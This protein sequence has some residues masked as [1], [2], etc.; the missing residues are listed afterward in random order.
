MTAAPTTSVA[1]RQTSRL[2]AVEHRASTF[3]FWVLLA[4]GLALRIVLLF[5]NSFRVDSDNAV[6]YLI[7]KHFSEGDVAWFFW[8]QTYGGTLLE[9]VAG[10]AMVVFGTHVEVLSIVGALFFVVATLLVRQIATE[11]FGRRLVGNVAGVLFWFPGYWMQRVGT[12]E[13]GFYG[14]SLMLGLLT[15]WLVLRGDRRKS[16]LQWALIGLAAGLAL[17]QSPMGIAIAAP[18][19]LVAVIRQFSPTRYLVGIAAAVLGALPWIIV[20]LTTATAVKPQRDTPIALVNFVAFFSRMLPGVL[21]FTHT[22]SAPGPGSTSSAIV[23]YPVAIIAVALIV[24]LLVLAITKRSWWLGTL[25]ASTVTVVVVVVLGTGL[26]LEVDSVRYAIFV[27][28]AITIGIAYVVTL[29]PLAGLGAM[30]VA[31]AFTVAQVLIIF[32]DLRV[33]RAESFIVGN[34]SV[35]GDYLEANDITGAYA[36]YW[37]S[38]SVTAET[39]ERAEVAALSGPR[40]YAPYEDTAQAAPRATVIVLRDNDNDRML[41][42]DASLPPSVRTEVGDYAVYSFA[43]PF[44][45]YSYAWAL[46]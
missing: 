41:Q 25:V 31:V 29:V 27:L 5:T 15:I 12:S 46:Y 11:A 6:V 24:M 10:A 36:D 35:L 30:A 13:P 43:Q 9:M 7:A 39:G 23:R 26:I 33:S 45:A 21:S 8:G 42:T 37:V 3:A 34:I 18:A 44:D 19:A 14:P 4:V 38:Y 32:P 20:F 2:R 17:W 40:R 28:P 1:P 22:P 16:H